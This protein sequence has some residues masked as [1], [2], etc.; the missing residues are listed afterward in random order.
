L[1]QRQV[2]GGVPA[3]RLF[4]KGAGLDDLLIVA[5]T[6]TNTEDDIEIF[7]NALREALA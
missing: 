3:S 4:G 5:A 7:T 1:A 2:L 6:E